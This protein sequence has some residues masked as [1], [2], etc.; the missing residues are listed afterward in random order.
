MSSS[1][2]RPT[3]DELFALLKNTNIPTVLV[4]GKD[5]IVFYRRIESDLDEI[6]IDMLPAGNKWAVLE[7]RDRIK[8]E[9][10]SAPVAFVVDKDLW[11]YFGG[12]A[13]LTDVITTDG[14]SI[15]NDIFIDGELLDLMSKE[16][17]EQFNIE[18]LKFSRWYALT[19]TRSQQ[20][21]EVSYR[22][23]PF[24]VINDNEFYNAA[25]KL[26]EEEQYP[27]DFFNMIHNHYGR[28]L[29]GKS[30]FALLVRQLSSS[31]RRTK[32]SVN[33]LMEVGASRKGE[34]YLMI[35]EK[36]RQAITVSETL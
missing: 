3:I 19:V 31:N 7:L 27:E 28:L 6:G 8:K 9:P 20:G 16:E 21:T 33:Q 36:I 15:E 2:V 35:R 24:K 4:E 11:V 34:R 14:Y 23:T 12:H 22:E 25:I 1:K 18:L 5:D 30:L 32:F 29:R 10:I 13:D 26:S 17:I